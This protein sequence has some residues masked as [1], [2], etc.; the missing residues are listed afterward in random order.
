M[1]IAKCPR[2]A[3]GRTIVTVAAVATYS[4]IAVTV[5]YVHANLIHTRCIPEYLT[6]A[7][8]R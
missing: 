5:P 4:I 3:T 6:V 1:V 8:A 2:I 7:A